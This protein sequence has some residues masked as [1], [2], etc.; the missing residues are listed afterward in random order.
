[1][2]GCGKRYNNFIKCGDF[3]RP[4]VTK[5]VYKQHLCSKCDAVHAKSETGGKD[6]KI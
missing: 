6:D 4:D 1:M 3:I 2:R 5:D